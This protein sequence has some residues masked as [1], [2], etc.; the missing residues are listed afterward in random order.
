MK[1]IFVC[2]ELQQQII[3]KS[4]EFYYKNQLHLNASNF[5]VEYNFREILL[6]TER[7]LNYK[8]YCIFRYFFKDLK[9]V[10]FDIKMRKYFF[11][12]K[13]FLIIN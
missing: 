10:F 1:I 12:N 2:K 7:S 13:M 8:D 5:F 6:V 3:K 11:W 9:I 4:Q